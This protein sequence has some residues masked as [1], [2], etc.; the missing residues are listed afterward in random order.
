MAD[1]ERRAEQHGVEITTAIERGPPGSTIVEYAEENDVDRIVMGS[2]DRSG[3]SK[4]LL[5]SVA[6]DVVKESPVTVTVVR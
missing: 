5:G 6:E 1:A 4:I 3:I 2:H